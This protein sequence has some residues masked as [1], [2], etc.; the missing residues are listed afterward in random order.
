MVS[1]H[2][3]SDIDKCIPISRNKEGQ[4]EGNKERLN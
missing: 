2:S 4:T 3:K 1:A